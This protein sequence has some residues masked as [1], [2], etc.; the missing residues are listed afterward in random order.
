VDP[1]AV[2]GAELR[3]LLEVALLDA[4]DDCADEIRRFWA[5]R[6]IGP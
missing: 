1:H 6:L 3:A 4:V 2:A 5:G